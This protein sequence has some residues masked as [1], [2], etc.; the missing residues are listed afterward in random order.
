M[1]G[2]ITITAPASYAVSTNG[3]DFGPSATITADASYVGSV[4][5]VRFAPD[6]FGRLQRAS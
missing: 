1:T 4:V 2:T 5:S 3:T 6:G